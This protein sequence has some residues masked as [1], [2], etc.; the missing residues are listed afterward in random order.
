MPDPEQKRDPGAGARYGAVTVVDGW[1]STQTDLSGGSS[2][3]S[4]MLNQHQFGTGLYALQIRGEEYRII[5][6][7]P[8][9][10]AH[11]MRSVG[12]AVEERVVMPH[13]DFRRL[14]DLRRGIA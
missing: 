10:V 2:F 7:Q 6:S 9:S 4:V 1:K 8:A 12:G 5:A 3:F 11:L 13:N 14:A